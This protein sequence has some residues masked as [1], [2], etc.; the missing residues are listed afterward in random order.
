MIVVFFSGGGGLFLLVFLL[1]ILSGAGYEFCNST[2]TFFTEHTV[3]LIVCSAIIVLLASLLSAY[4]Q[5]NIKSVPCT[6]LVLSQMMFCLFYGMYSMTLAADNSFFL[7]LISLTVYAAA[8]AVNSIIS[9]HVTLY[10]MKNQKFNP[11]YIWGVAGWISNLI[12][13]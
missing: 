5:K 10:S 12:F 11:M 4:M 1:M 8:F 9:A 6:F 3:S 13:W 7:L 2:I